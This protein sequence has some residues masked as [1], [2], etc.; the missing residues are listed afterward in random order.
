MKKITVRIIAFVL[1]LSLTITMSLGQY[2][3]AQATGLGAA[4]AAGAG[5]SGGVGL[6]ILL[7]ICGVGVFM[8]DDYTQENIED[9]YDQ[10]VDDLAG[11]TTQGIQNN[12]AGT[13]EWK[14]NFT[15]NKEVINDFLESLSAGVIDVTSDAWDWFRQFINEIKGNAGSEGSYIGGYPAFGDGTWEFSKKIL[16][17]GNYQTYSIILSNTDVLSGS[18]MP[19]ICQEGSGLRVRDYLTGEYV[20]VNATVQT[21]MRDYDTNGKM[22]H[23]YKVINQPD[24]VNSS[25]LIDWT[26]SGVHWL[27]NSWNTSGSVG[28]TDIP[29]VSNPGAYVAHGQDCLVGANAGSWDLCDPLGMNRP[30]VLGPDIPFGANSWGEVISGVVTGEQSWTDVASAVGIIGVESDIPIGGTDERVNTGEYTAVIPDVGSLALDAAI[31]AA[32]DAS[33]DK[34]KDEESSKTDVSYDKE[35]GA[36]MLDFKDFFPFCIPFDIYYFVKVLSATPVAP[37]IHYKFYV[38]KTEYYNIDINLNKF[39]EV[40][41]ILRTMELLLFIVGLAFITRSMIIRG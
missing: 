31:D 22:T 20:K 38:S 25:I 4:G 29:G 39:N 28:A 6:L 24:V 15:Q 16:N 5:L 17:Q 27:V 7:G 21:Q 19:I 40:A 8:S 18:S 1:C 2:R 35:N 32:W 10:F 12:Q 37:I 26:V 30:V 11:Y 36:Y 13:E 14:K 23:E 3:K 9:A 41:E 33:N 34:D